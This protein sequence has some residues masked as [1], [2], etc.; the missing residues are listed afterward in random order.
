VAAPAFRKNELRGYMVGTFHVQ[1]LLAS[2]LNDY[3]PAGYWVTVLDGSDLLYQRSKVAV[4]AK[5]ADV[6]EGSINVMG[7][8]WTVR[9]GPTPAGS[10]EFRSNLPDAV[11]LVGV[12]LAI[13]LSFTTVLGQ[14]SHRWA[15]ALERAN[16]ELEQ[17][18][19]QR[20]LWG[21]ALRQA[22]ERLEIVI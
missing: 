10:M 7:M 11:M 16:S 21:E 6:S 14:T 5:R 8:P 17:Q 4:P 18:I 15:K 22:K 9:V 1:E 13:L 3:I 2:V 19:T 12:L 20:K